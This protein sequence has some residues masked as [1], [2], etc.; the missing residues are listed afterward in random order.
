MSDTP[1]ILDIYSVL[2]DNS[3]FCKD[4][5][6]GDQVRFEVIDMLRSGWSP[7]RIVRHLYH[8]LGIEIPPPH[9]VELREAL[10]PA[11]FLAPGKLAEKLQFV[12]LEIDALG[13]LGRL[14]K[15]NETRLATLLE[16]EK[17]N[18]Q[19][20][21]ATDELI[22]LQTKQLRE[23]IELK[24]KLGLLPQEAPEI[25]ATVH[26]EP[27]VEDILKEH[28]IRSDRPGSDSEETP[29]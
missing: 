9:V 7:S 10:P 26:R 22:K 19:N 5:S 14:I 3:S 12:D 25:H 27:T 4:S 2:V 17:D 23:Y 16:L 15:I 1:F 11:A 29:D 6:L 20:F 24:M 18:V 8:T 21:E 28:G 13:D